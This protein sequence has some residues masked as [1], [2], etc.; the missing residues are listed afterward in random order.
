MYIAASLHAAFVSWYAVSDILICTCSARVYPLEALMMDCREYFRTTG[1][2]VTFEY[3]VLAGVNDSPVL[4]QQL[5]SLLTR[6]DMRSHVNLIQWNPV[7]ESDYKRPDKAH[8][9]AFAEV[10]D[11]ARVPVSIRKSRGMEAAA[12]CGQLRNEHQKQPLHKFTVL[13]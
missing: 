3:T 13:A 9:R 12:A 8:M 4:A 11:K 1:R 5:A 10:L 6:F 7:D 2:R